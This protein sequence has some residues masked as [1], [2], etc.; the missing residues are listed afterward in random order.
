MEGVADDPLFLQ[1]IDDEELVALSE[2]IF[3]RLTE[4]R[5]CSRIVAAADRRRADPQ[6]SLPTT[7]FASSS[8]S[9]IRICAVSFADVRG[10]RHTL[11]VQAESL[12]EAAILA[13]RTFR[14]DPCTVR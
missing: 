4:L 13:V 2:R 7:T 14:D 11:E 12:F 8:K 10:F 1:L 3:G 5:R 9:R 6:A